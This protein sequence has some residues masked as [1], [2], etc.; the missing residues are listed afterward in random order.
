MAKVRQ[1][2]NII[3]NSEEYNDMSKMRQIG[4]MY[5][6]EKRKLN[7]KYN[8]KKDNVVGRNFQSSAPGKTSGRKYKMVDRRLKKD[9][10]ATKRTEKKK[11]GKGGRVK[12]KK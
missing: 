7:D 6:T 2:A 8:T 11:K 4:K 1:R 5:S 12:M 9:V 10:R 3:A